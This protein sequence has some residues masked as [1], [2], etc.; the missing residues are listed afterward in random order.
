MSE[1]SWIAHERLRGRISSDYAKLWEF[2]R[3]LDPVC[4]SVPYE[5]LKEEAAAIWRP[6]VHRILRSF[7]GVWEVEGLDP[8]ILDQYDRDFYEEFPEFNEEEP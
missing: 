5:R 3:T 6:H 4:P 8:A 7:R 2:A 1:E